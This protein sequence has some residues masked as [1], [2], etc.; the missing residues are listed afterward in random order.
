[1]GCFLSLHFGIRESERRTRRREQQNLENPVS[2]NAR[3]ELV[4]SADPIIL[5]PNFQTSD[6]NN[7]MEK[8]LRALFL[9]N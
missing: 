1:M 5:F 4:N 7:S 8:Y 2:S 3:D 9:F 6:D